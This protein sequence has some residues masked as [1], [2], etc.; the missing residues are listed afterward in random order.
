MCFAN[1]G[2]AI[3]E[4][5]IPPQISLLSLLSLL[6]AN[7]TP[8]VSL[9]LFVRACPTC[10]WTV[11][12]VRGQTYLLQLCV[13]PGFVEELSDG[14]EDGQHQAGGEHDE[15]AA[16]VLHAEGTGL[17]ALLLGAA[18]PTP[19]LLLHHVQLALLLQLQD[20][21]GDLVPVRRT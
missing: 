16:D 12:A 21:D 2:Q 17:L 13:L 3:P 20:G 18:V 6:H 11:V 14:H 15:D 7:L 19:P 1:G 9:A 8:Q 4:I 5:H 10:P